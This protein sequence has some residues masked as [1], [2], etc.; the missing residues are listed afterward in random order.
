MQHF[1]LGAAARRV[2]GFCFW[3]TFGVVACLVLQPIVVLLLLFQ[4]WIS[5]LDQADAILLTGSYVLAIPL[6]LCMAAMAVFAVCH[7][8]ILWRA[9]QYRAAVTATF[10][11]VVFALFIGYVW[12][13]WSEIKNEKVRSLI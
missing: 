11:F 12:F 4:G 6:F 9:G 5:T 2:F 7:L 13:Y 8:V 10:E 3:C 1:K